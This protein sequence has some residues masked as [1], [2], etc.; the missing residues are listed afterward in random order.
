[1]GGW[2]QGAAN[3]AS[4]LAEWAGPDVDPHQIEKALPPLRRS[5]RGTRWACLGRGRKKSLGVSEL[6]EDVATC[7]QSVVS[8]A[9]ELLGEDVQE[10]SADELDGVEGERD[11][12]RVLAIVLRSE[13]DSASVHRNQP[14]IGN[15]DAVCVVAE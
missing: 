5:L 11:P 4:R 6:G 12:P 10:E 15:G 8:D 14:V 1:M 13:T 2:R 7:E 9:D 3:K